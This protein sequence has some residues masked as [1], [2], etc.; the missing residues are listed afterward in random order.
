[1]SLSDPAEGPQVQ[2]REGPS[3]ARIQANLLHP[4]LLLTLIISNERSSTP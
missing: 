1:M 2:K 3:P 4:A